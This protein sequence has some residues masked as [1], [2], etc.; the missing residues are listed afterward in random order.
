[1]T[2]ATLTAKTQLSL[3]AQKVVAKR[4]ALK[5]QNGAG[6][7]TET[8][9]DIVERVVTFVARAE[10]EARR[11]D[12]FTETMR[13]ILRARLFVPNTPCL[14]NMANRR[15]CSPPASYCRCLRSEEIMDHA[16]YCALVHQQGGGTGMTYER[17]R[18]AGS[19][20][21][22]SR[23]AASGPVSFMQIVNTMPKVVK[24]GGVRHAVRIWAFYPSHIL[25]SCASFMPERSEKPDEFQYF[26]HGHR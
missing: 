2:S 5:D 21:S 18:P 24:Q 19:S 20:V 6:N 4:Y 22:D 15:R 16:K 25:T 1:M 9:D 7:P 23:G 8:W 17:L 11:R 13:E 14:V 26:R 10:T 12:E 3:N